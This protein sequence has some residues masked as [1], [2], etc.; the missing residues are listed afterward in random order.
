MIIWFDIFAS[1]TFACVTTSHTFRKAFSIF[2]K[3]VRLF[4]IATDYMLSL[5]TLITKFW[6]EGMW[7]TI[8]DKVHCFSTLF[9]MFFCI[10]TTYAITVVTEITCCK[11]IAI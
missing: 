5:I 10:A 9:F 8:K 6:F 7:I 1:C 11:A 3:A 4:A 2:L